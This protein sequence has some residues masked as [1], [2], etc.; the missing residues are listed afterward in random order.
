[1]PAAAVASHHAPERN[2]SPLSSVLYL[3][4]LQ[5]GQDNALESAWREQL[6]RR[7]L[8]LIGDA[9]AISTGS[10]SLQPAFDFAAAA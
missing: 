2:S 8:P 3:A 10:R 5:A 1:M 4:E 7:R 6:A 9:G